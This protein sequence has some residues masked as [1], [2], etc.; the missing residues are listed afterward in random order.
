MS[1]FVALKRRALE[2]SIPLAAYLELTYACNWRCVFCYNPRHHD[3]R[4]LRLGEWI[5]VLDDLRALG[6]LTVVLTGGEPLV[7]PDFLAIA[8][9]VRERAF[10]LKLFTNGS[11]VDEPTA[12]AI[13]ELLPLAVELSLHGATAATHDATTARP[14]SFTALWQ[15]IDRLRRHGVPLAL[16]TPLTCLNEGELEA[17]LALARDAGLPL[18]VDPT[19]TPRDDGDRGPL[20]WR[21]S[22]EA[23]AGLMRRLLEAGTLPEERRETGGTNCGLGRLTVAVDPEGNV[24]PCMQWR[25][26]SLGNV[27][28]TPLRR[29]WGES[30]ERTAAAAAARDAN[31]RL[32]ALGG[33]AASFPFCPALAMQHTGDPARP[34]DLFFQ[35]AE[36]AAELRAEAAA[37]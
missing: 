11:L 35:Q 2:R 8:R 12:A 25:H 1:G 27:R 7:H 4:R 33:A 21:A 13:A 31:D 29:L 16:K 18:R 19:L 36:I 5:P 15:A 23:T 34:D 37:G 28:A 6:A 22:R 24:Y 30:A 26:T 3:L 20:R 32:V 17:L 10:A 9:A 14:G